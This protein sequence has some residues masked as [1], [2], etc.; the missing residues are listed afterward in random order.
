M[1]GSTFLYESPDD[2]VY[3]RTISFANF[4]CVSQLPFEKLA[5]GAACSISMS[6]SRQYSLNSEESKAGSLSE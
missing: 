4:I 6:L 5:Y 1:C 3:A 2:L